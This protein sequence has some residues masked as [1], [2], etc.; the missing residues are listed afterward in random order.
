MK[1]LFKVHKCY[2]FFS[3][4]DNNPY[5]VVII[6]NVTAGEKTLTLF[7][8]VFLMD[9]GVVAEVKIQHSKRQQNN[10]RR[11]E[12]TVAEMIG[13]KIQQSANKNV[14]VFP[15]S[16]TFQEDIKYWY[17]TSRQAVHYLF[18]WCNIIVFFVLCSCLYLSLFQSILSI[19]LIDSLASII[20]KKVDKRQM[21]IIWD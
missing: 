15:I 11:P 5:G 7:C 13:Y 17:L 9:T 2:C 1:K 19:Y 18:G 4:F 3:T 10:W 8:D 21:I 6:K 12:S 14:Y 20:K 16:F